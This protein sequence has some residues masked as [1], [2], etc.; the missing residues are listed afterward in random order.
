MYA[1]D[2]ALLRHALT[3]V[4]SDN[5]QGE[6]YLTDVIAIA[7]KAGGT[8]RAH[9]RRPVPGRRL[10]RSCPAVRSRR[11]TEPP[12]HP[13]TPARR[14]HR[15]RP[16]EYLIDVDVAIAPDVTIEPGTQLRGRTTIAE[17]AVVGPDTTL[18]DV[19]VGS[20]RR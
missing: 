5:A 12:H 3:K 14:G 19:T 8:V 20:A 11:R 6:F 16:I 2:A 13:R 17:D 7:R 9:R 15:R 4:S 10:Q 1:F 18:T